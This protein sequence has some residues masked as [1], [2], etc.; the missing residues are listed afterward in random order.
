MWAVLV[1]PVKKKSCVFIQF[2]FLFLFFL[3]CRGALHQLGHG[4]GGSGGL[5]MEEGFGGGRAGVGGDGAG[6]GGAGDLS[7]GRWRRRRQEE[8]GGV[9]DLL[10]RSYR[11][12]LS[13]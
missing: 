5:W 1:I 12:E 10:A 7:G 9:D 4:E 11:R 6:G 13:F 8:S 3:Q 2:S